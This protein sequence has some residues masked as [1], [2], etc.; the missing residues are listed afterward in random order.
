MNDLHN[1]LA[2]GCLKSVQLCQNGTRAYFQHNWRQLPAWFQTLLAVAT[3]AAW[4]PTTG[5][6]KPWGAR[7]AVQ[8]LRAGALIGSNPYKSFCDWR[9]IDI[10]DESIYFYDQWAPEEWLLL[11]QVLLKSR[12]CWFLKNGYIVN[13]SCEVVSP[14][15]SYSAYTPG[16][17][18]Y[19]L[20]LFRLSPRL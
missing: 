2:Q 13:S 9:I 8:A 18:S 6:T 5:K 10:T 7:K 14:W 12:H 3:I 17:M 16:S 4:V 11:N 1:S 19:R 20:A 15:S